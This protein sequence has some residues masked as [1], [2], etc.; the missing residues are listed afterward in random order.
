[1]GD[2]GQGQIYGPYQ[3]EREAHDAVIRMAGPGDPP[4][5]SVLSPGQKWQLL[6]DACAASKLALGEHDKR[7]LAWLADYPDSSVAVIT[8]LILRA[9]GQAHVPV[10]VPPRAVERAATLRRWMTADPE[11]D[12][13]EDGGGEWTVQDVIT[14]ALDQGLDA[15]ERLYLPSR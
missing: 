8:G 11:L 10:S 14:A 13:P 5:P 9:S 7:V 6:S 1:V 2:A 4:V 3:V 12:A 15:L